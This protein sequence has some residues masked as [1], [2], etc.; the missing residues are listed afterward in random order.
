MTKRTAII[1]SVSAALVLAVAAVPA[2]AQAPQDESTRPTI[3]TEHN[4]ATMPHATMAAQM[5][6]MN[7]NMNMDMDMDMEDMDMH[8]QMHEQ[9]HAMMEAG[10]GGA[11]HG[12]DGSAMPGAGAMRGT[13]GTM[14]ESGS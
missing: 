10:H 8:E 5:G 13:S 4:D 2:T 6:D 14:M 1:T 3:S 7:M 12:A 9:M 11:G